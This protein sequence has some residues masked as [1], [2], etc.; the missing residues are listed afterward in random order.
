MQRRPDHAAHR[1]SSIARDERGVV[2]I[3]FALVLPL[4]L[5]V[6]F[7]IVDFGRVFNYFNDANQIAA[8]GARAAAVAGP[9]ADQGAFVAGLIDSGTTE[10]L[11]AGSDQ[12]TTPLD[13]CVILPNG[14]SKTGDPITIRVTSEFELLPIIPGGISIP[15]KGEA[16]MRIERDLNFTADC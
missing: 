15:I 7:L 14:T 3:E 1:R 12:V 2:A 9:L 5:L 16:T 10:E 11:R 13:A 6:L 8:E 4:L